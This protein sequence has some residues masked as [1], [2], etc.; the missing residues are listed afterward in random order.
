MLDADRHVDSTG[1][2][3]RGVTTR[4]TLVSYRRRRRSRSV[5]RRRRRR[6]CR[7]RMRRLQTPV[8]DQ[9]ES[10]FSQI[11]HYTTR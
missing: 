7:R 2:D 4:R 11:T 8:S 5:H 9:L 10:L 6:R 3:H 1:P